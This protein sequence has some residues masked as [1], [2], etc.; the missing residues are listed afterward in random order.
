MQYLSAGLKDLLA[1]NGIILHPIVHILPG[2]CRGDISHTNIAAP[3]AIMKFG[4]SGP[5]LQSGRYNSGSWFFP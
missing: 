1:L 4:F 2:N 3:A 5:K